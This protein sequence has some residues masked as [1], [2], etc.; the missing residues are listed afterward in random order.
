VQTVGYTGPSFRYVSDSG[1]GNGV[2][3]TDNRISSFINLVST[4]EPREDVAPEIRKGV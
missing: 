2:L 1:S 4:L 3:E